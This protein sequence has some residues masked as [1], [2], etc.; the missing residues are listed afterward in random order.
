MHTAEWA[1]RAICKGCQAIS[2]QPGC[3]NLT[4]ERPTARYCGICLGGA[5]KKAGRGCKGAWQ[6]R[7]LPHGMRVQGG[8]RMGAQ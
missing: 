8:V 4:S 7:A 6:G 3:L 1:S 2:A 5:G